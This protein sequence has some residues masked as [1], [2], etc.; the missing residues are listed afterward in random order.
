[1]ASPF[2]IVPID[3]G[4]CAGLLPVPKTLKNAV[5]KCPPHVYIVPYIIKWRD[6]NFPWGNTVY[7]HISKKASTAVLLYVMSMGKPKAINMKA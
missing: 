3:G 1:M 5:A 6:I 7:I 4:N 2:H